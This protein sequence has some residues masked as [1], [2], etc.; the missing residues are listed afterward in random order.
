MYRVGPYTIT[1]HIDAGG[2]ATVWRA[3]H[4]QT[5]RDVAIKLIT[6]NKKSLSSTLDVHDEIRALARLDHPHSPYF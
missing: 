2:M 3:T 4:T 5:G 1:S 6:P